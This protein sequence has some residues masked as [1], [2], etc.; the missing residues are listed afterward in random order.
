MSL[1]NTEIEK[2]NI[3][4]KTKLGTTQV[5]T[6]A[7]INVVDNLKITKVLTVNAKP[8]V[9]N[10]S[11]VSS[12]VKFDG[13]VDYDLLVV[14]ENENIVPLTQKSSFSQVFE[15]AAITPDSVINIYSDVIELKDISSSNE[16][17]Y[18]STI[19]FDVYLISQ[20]SEI[21]CAKPVDNVFVKEGEV[22]YN[23]F[24][25]NIVYD[26][27]VNFEIVKDS[28]VNKILYINNFASIKS[29]IPSN[30][31]FIVSG[32]V[33]SS[34]IF[35]SEEGEV[36][37]LNKTSTFSEE[38]ECVGVTKE[39]IIQAQIKTKESTIVENT[40]KAIFSFDTP[41]KILAQIYNKST[42]KC[43]V[44]A[45][46]LKNDVNLTTTSFEEDEFIATR[47][48]EENLLT[49]FAIADNVPIVDKILAITPINISLVNQIVRNGELV[50][51]GI[52]NI[53]L[54]YFFE[55]EDGQNILNSLD[56]ELP[57]SLNVSIPDIKENDRVITQIVLGDINIKNKRGKELEI[58]A[59][60]KI[61]YDIIK[62]NISAVTTQILIGEEKLQ[63]DYSLEIYLAKENQSLWDVAKELNIS[64]S[65]LVSQNADLTLPLTKGEKI[66][67]F[68]QRTIDFD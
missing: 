11:V 35:Q 9:E 7:S 63:K 31:Y 18:S 65:D 24:V 27:M 49:N 20:N 54:I 2:L 37:S 26:G 52:V 36:K 60:I 39:S 29:V 33:Y 68:K 59:E 67:S 25:N 51:E 22:L 43:V 3:A 13:V 17:A 56:I 23:S 66:I 30:D 21:C 61:N 48:L 4:T 50:L 40:E 8:R 55:D 64:T 57:Y 47:Q 19:L 58:L 45:Y 1:D 53:N 5:K 6:T 28:K 62:N 32:E 38:I 46:S 12:E 41:I 42:A 34:I 10:I 15:N 16:I 14:L 44:D